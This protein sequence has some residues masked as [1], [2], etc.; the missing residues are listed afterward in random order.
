MCYSLKYI[1][2]QE[3]PQVE[4]KIEITFR[5]AEEEHLRAVAIKSLEPFKDEVE[6]AEPVQEA[7]EEQEAEKKQQ[8]NEEV[9]NLEPSL[10]DVESGEGFVVYAKASGSDPV[11]E[12]SKDKSQVSNHWNN[13]DRICV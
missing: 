13:S 8:F 5:P 6:K 2:F 11:I 1:L 9:E 3:Q 4:E 10:S 7:V 12:V